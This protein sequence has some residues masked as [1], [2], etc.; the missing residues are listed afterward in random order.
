MDELRQ[1]EAEQQANDAAERR[2]RHRFAEKESEDGPARRAERDQEADLAGALG[3]RDGHDGDDADAADGERYAAQRADGQGQDVEDVGQGAQHVFLRGDGE[4]LAA[5]ARLERRDDR[6][7][8]A[9]Y[10]ATPSS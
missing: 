2:E 4:V 5:V 1:A 6:L 7:A 10:A 8:D 3:D 9:R